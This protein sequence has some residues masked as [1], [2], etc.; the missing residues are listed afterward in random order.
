MKPFTLS[1]TGDYAG[2]NAD[3]SNFLNV[4]EFQKINQNKFLQL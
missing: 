2:S 4:E 3:Q 1:I